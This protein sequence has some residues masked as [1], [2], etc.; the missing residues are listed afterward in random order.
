M[1]A[2]VVPPSGRRLK[3][4]FIR[5]GHEVESRIADDGDHAVRSLILMAASIEILIDGDCFKIKSA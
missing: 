5:N 3:V 1:P 4:I 2:H